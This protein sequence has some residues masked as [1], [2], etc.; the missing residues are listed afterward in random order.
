MDATATKLSASFA[1]F[2]EQATNVVISNNTPESNPALRWAEPFP[3]SINEEHVPESRSQTF[4]IGM[5]PN[6]SADSLPRLRGKNRSQ[7]DPLPSILKSGMTLSIDNVLRASNTGLEGQKD[8]SLSLQSSKK[9][10]FASTHC[11]NEPAST[12]SSS[13]QPAQ[14][15]QHNLE[16]IRSVID[17]QE[18]NANAGSLSNVKSI[19]EIYQFYTNR[20]HIARIDPIRTIVMALEQSFTNDSN[21]TVLDL[22]GVSITADN[23]ST[24]HE[25]LE[26]KFGLKKLSLRCCDLNNEMLRTL[27]NALLVSNELEWLSLAGNV[28]IKGDGIK[29]IAVFMMKAQKLQYLDMSGIQMD[30]KGAKYMRQGLSNKTNGTCSPLQVLRLEDCRLRADHLSS[31]AVGVSQSNVTHL[32][33][34]TNKMPFDCAPSLSLLLTLTHQDSRH[35]AHLD[36]SGNPTL[37][38]DFATLIQPLARTTFLRHLALRE[39]ALTG[40]NLEELCAALAVNP[41]STLASLDLGGNPLC[42]GGNLGGMVGLKVYLMHSQV[43]REVSLA[44]CGLTAEAVLVLSEGMSVSKSLHRVDLSRNPMD[45]GGIVA[46]LGAVKICRTIF[47]MDLE[48]ILQEDGSVNNDDDMV[49]MVRKIK[50]ECGQH[51]EVHMAKLEK[52]PENQIDDGTGLEFS[53]GF[54]FTVDLGNEL[55]NPH[56]LPASRQN[57]GQRLE[58]Q[59][60]HET[61][62][63]SAAQFL[64]AMRSSE[65]T[66][67]VLEEM[68]DNLEVLLSEPEALQDKGIDKDIMKDLRRSC[69]SFKHKI[70]SALSQGYLQDES[71]V[72][73]CINLN[74]RIDAALARYNAVMI[75]MKS[76]IDSQLAPHKSHGS[77]ALQNFSKDLGNSITDMA[78]KMFGF[79][80]QMKHTSENATHTN[81]YHGTIQNATQDTLE[82]PLHPGIKDPHEVSV[83]TAAVTESGPSAP[84]TRQDASQ[85]SPRDE[86]DLNAPA[87]QFT[88]ASSAMPPA[89]LS[90]TDSDPS[91]RKPPRASA[92]VDCEDNGSTFPVIPP[93][94]ILVIKNSR[95]PIAVKPGLKFSALPPLP[96][97]VSFSDFD[98]V[99]EEA[100]LSRGW[101]PSPKVVAP[102]HALA[103]SDLKELDELLSS[104]SLESQITM[105]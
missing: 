52:R 76:T 41:T 60:L 2:K 100:M 68:M 53:V 94:Q 104:T 37:R 63:F 81:S 84:A 14:V 47:H 8:G 105:E 99:S 96:K 73:E 102:A 38:L 69:S 64:Q 22:S 28:N 66:C 55:N 7:L 33:L 48:P 36:L 56:T 26:L 83:L 70:Q 16:I 6:S 71:T 89:L 31:L 25:L 93:S 27:L 9:V 86:S 78:S 61:E 20:C 12:S 59:Y 44:D 46:L 88:T 3:P 101:R 30:D 45:M 80:K 57:D 18:Q 87:I 50:G 62:L 5:S 24:L 32:L 23:A 79:V 72:L 15:E 75:V 29:Y 51:N 11:E 17:E 19:A 40:A 92:N 35:L 39:N 43:L 98:D 97:P 77:D 49:D 90:T 1:K 54:E 4:V 13:S 10:Q 67:I 82:N 65:E 21:V 42:R 58:P 95:E 85:L 91:P 103:D 34:G 74:D